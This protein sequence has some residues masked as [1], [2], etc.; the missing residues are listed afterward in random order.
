MVAEKNTINGFMKLNKYLELV[1]MLE[2]TTQQETALRFNLNVNKVKG[3]SGNCSLG[4]GKH[5]VIYNV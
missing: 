1:I 2:I 5:P 4:W 3:S